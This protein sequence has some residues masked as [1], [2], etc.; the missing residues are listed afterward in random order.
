MIPH[1]PFSV[2]IFSQPTPKGGVMNFK[3]YLVR[4]KTHTPG[5]YKFYR[6]CDDVAVLLDTGVPEALRRAICGIEILRRVKAEDANTW[7]VYTVFGEEHLE[8]GEPALHISE[9]SDGGAFKRVA[10]LHAMGADMHIYVYQHCGL[11]SFGLDERGRNEEA[12]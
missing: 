5:L 12:D 4:T 1:I 9:H 2:K 6:S 7:D 8:H 3:P 10:E 11:E